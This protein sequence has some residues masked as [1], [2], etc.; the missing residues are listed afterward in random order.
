[1]LGAN[2]ACEEVVAALERHTSNEAAL[3]MTSST[4]RA[5]AALAVQWACL[6]IYVLGH[7]HPSH[8]DRFGRSNACAVVARAVSS[9]NNGFAD[10]ETAAYAACQ[11]ICALAKNSKKH[12][13]TLSISIYLYLSIHD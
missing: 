2:N 4:S 11:A 12:Q 1:M 10:S 8:Q 5:S 3:L 9:S 6:A 7:E 13:G